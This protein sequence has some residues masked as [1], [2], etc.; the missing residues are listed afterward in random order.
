MIYN[1]DLL[2]ITKTPDLALR[3]IDDIAYGVAGTTTEENVEALNQTL[4]A[5]E[6]WRQRHGA[7][8]EP[9]KYMLV[10][11]TRKKAETHN[12]KVAIQIRDTTIQPTTE[13]RYLSIIFDQKLKFRAHLN[14]AIKRG[15]KFALAMTNIT[16]CT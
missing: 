15:T 5:S 9:S 2:E 7:Q 12:P 14:Y 1:A 10:H 11:F 16:K 13:A 3:F 6:T 4:R 8:F